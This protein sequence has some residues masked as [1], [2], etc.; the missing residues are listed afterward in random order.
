MSSI[1]ENEHKL[2]VG[3][4]F[5]GKSAEHEVSIQSA[6]NIF[7]AIDRDKFEPVL[8]GID[9]QGG[10]SLP[11]S[12]AVGAI[13]SS[14]VSQLRLSLGGHNKLIAAADKVSFQTPD[15]IF[16]ILHGPLGEDGAVQGL[17]ELASIPYVGAGIL[18]S[19]V[20][21]DKDVMKRLL[22][23]AG[24]PIAKY[25]VLKDPDAFD[26]DMIITTL[27]TPLFVKPAN[28]GS[29]IGVSKVTNREELM[30]AVALGFRYDRKVLVEEAIDGD[31]V[32]CAIIGN[33]HPE[34]SVPGRII[35]KADFY[36]YDAK[37]EEGE[38]TAI[39]IPARLPA[40]LNLRIQEVALKTF[41]VLECEGMA[42]VDMFVTKQGEILVNEINTLPGF[43]KMSVYPQLWEAS[44]LSYT[45]LITKLL[46]LA[47]DRAVERKKLLTDRNAVGVGE[48]HK[49]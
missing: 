30:Q 25:V 4:L 49:T 35:V 1:S 15:V 5:G 46:E 41:K 19:A 27:G 28:M 17:L 40:A 23:E 26:P 10:W 8:V 45:D 6:G 14:P 18:G 33:Q 22:H 44:G 21:M 47:I 24:I 39:E 2:R 29:S 37:Y 38:G 7:E 9:K 12:A 16:P 32:E 48:D 3:I 36:T 43:T 34:A 20:G 11:S 31:E 42:R 13:E